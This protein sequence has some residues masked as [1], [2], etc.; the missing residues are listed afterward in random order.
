MGGFCA[1][2]WY[3]YIKSFIFYFRNGFD[4]SEDFGPKISE[5]PDDDR[6]TVKPR[7]KFFVAWPVFVVV[8]SVL[9][10]SV[11]LAL[12]GVLGRCVDCAL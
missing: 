1:Y 10:L 2:S 5:F 4:F 8:T 6:F 11:V 3:W 9:L 7:E 12:L